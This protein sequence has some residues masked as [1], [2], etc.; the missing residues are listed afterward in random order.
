MERTSGTG[1]VLIFPHE[2]SSKDRAKE[3]MPLYSKYFPL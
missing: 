1:M 2:S 3:S